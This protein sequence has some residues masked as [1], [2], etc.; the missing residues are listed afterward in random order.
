MNTQRSSKSLVRT[1]SETKLRMERAISFG[2]TEVLAMKHGGKNV[3]N[4]SVDQG[5]I[6]GQRSKLL[7]GRYSKENADGKC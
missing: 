5:T 2:C 1:L 4:Q 7:T 6:A 3:D